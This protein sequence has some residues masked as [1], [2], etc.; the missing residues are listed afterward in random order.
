MLLRCSAR[1]A[2]QR[3]GTTESIRYKGQWDK[4]KCPR[5]WGIGGRTQPLVGGFDLLSQGLMVHHIKGLSEMHQGRL[6]CAH[7]L[8]HKGLMVH[9]V[10]RNC[11][12]ACAL[13]SKNMAQ[14]VHGP[15]CL[16]K[17]ASGPTQ[18]VTDGFSKESMVLHA[19]LNI[20][21]VMPSGNS[22]AQRET[23]TF[24]SLEPGYSL[25]IWQVMLS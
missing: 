13:C 3:Q 11:I 5:S 25:I 19:G 22:D 14:C 7:R 9:P 20:W 8:R 21:Q 24:F 17:V 16:L 6:H 10:C 12:R 1:D 18:R 4:G 15:S 23:R 2:Q